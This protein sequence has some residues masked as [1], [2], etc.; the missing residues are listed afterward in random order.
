M[1]LD[2]MTAQIV[3]IEVLV[4]GY[5]NS[6]TNA[7]LHPEQPAFQSPLIGVS[8]VDMLDV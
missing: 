7:C 4:C 8:P 3:V 2:A 1:G 6:T 5:F